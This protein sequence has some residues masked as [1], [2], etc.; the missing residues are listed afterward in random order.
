MSS[1]PSD[2]S[3][4]AFKPAGRVTVITRA[5]RQAGRDL[6]LGPRQPDSAGQILRPLDDLTYPPSGPPIDER[7]RGPAAASRQITETPEIPVLQPP[8]NGLSWPHTR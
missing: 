5:D 3:S 7:V 2:P 6:R 4:L 1:P 8:D